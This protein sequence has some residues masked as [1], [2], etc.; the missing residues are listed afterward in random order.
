MDEKTR[1]MTQEALG[2][3]PPIPLGKVRADPV[4]ARALPAIVADAVQRREAALDKLVDR[5]LSWPLPKSVCSDLCATDPNYP[6]QRSGTNL[7][8]AIEAKEMLKHVA[9]DLLHDAECWQM[10]MFEAQRHGS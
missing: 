10:A 1:R 4:S 9:G 6:H 8:T 7:L 3:E 5:F 2:S